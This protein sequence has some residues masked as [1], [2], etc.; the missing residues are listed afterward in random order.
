[1]AQYRL[2]PLIVNAEQNLTGEVRSASGTL[3]APP[4]HWAVTG[5]GEEGSKPIIMKD[6]MFQKLCM[7]AEAGA[8]LYQ[9]LEKLLAANTDELY[10]SIPCCFRCSQDHRR[11]RSADDCKCPGHCHQIRDMLKRMP[12]TDVHAAGHDQHQGTPQQQR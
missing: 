11:G 9:M 10:P 2:R 7:P 3:S 12:A 1:M 6:A 8:D 5:L 4:G